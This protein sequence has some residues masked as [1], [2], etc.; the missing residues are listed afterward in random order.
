MKH[1]IYY[2][3]RRWHDGREPFHSVRITTQ[4][5]RKAM[6]VPLA[7][8]EDAERTVLRVLRKEGFITD[9]VTDSLRVAAGEA[10]Y[11]VIM[12]GDEQ[13]TRRRMLH[14]YGIGAP[15]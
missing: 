12:T 8:G 7:H 6:T 15:T 4:A 13:V 9:Q 1:P 11:Q 2:Q 10:G 14:D 5:R 3:I